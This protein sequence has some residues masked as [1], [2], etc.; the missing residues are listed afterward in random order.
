M[1]RAINAANL[2]YFLPFRRL[3]DSITNDSIKLK[4]LNIYIEEM[5][6][7]HLGQAQDVLVHK[8]GSVEQLPTLEEY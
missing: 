3:Y 6:L 1:G 8:V 4:I 5:I 7:C 2:M